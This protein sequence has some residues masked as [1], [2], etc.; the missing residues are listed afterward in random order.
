[1]ANN[2]EHPLQGKHSSLKIKISIT[3]TLEKQ[4]QSLY[5]LSFSHVP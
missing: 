4:Q 5:L 1:M 2:P 3:I